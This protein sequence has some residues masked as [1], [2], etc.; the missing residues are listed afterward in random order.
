MLPP[1]I[2]FLDDNLSVPGYFNT[3][4]PN[5]LGRESTLVLV[6]SR[7][8]AAIFNKFMLWRSGLVRQKKKIDKNSLSLLTNKYSYR[9][10]DQQ[11]RPSATNQSEKF[12]TWTNPCHNEETSGHHTRTISNFRS[13]HSMTNQLIKKQ[14]KWTRDE[15]HYTQKSTKGH[16]G[17]DIPNMSFGKNWWMTLSQP[18]YACHMSAETSCEIKD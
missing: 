5:F 1:W 6:T 12:L 11:K 14:T 10:P 8:R 7:Q 13:S 4:P 17:A 18:K 9:H 3:Y 2:K 15:Y 16:H